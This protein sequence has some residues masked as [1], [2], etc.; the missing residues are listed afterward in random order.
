MKSIRSFTLKVAMG[1][2]MAVCFN[3]G[4]ANA[5]I[6]AGKFTLPFETHWGPNTLP[7]GNYS[8]KLDETSGPGS[9]LQVF[10]GD[11]SVAFVISRSHDTNPSGRISLTVL[12]N[13]SGNTVRDLNLPQI[14]MVFHYAP[15]PE[16]ASA[17]E[18]R[19]IAQIPIT[20][21]GK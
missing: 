12:R 1:S 19:E 8:F 11:Q 20:S 21:A 18:E 3:T 14:G 4:V 9:I 13:R 17:A 16:H 10:H 7:A 15:K 5:Q 6:L 2:L